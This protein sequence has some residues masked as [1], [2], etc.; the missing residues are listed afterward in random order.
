M[1]FLCQIVV[2]IYLD[3]A[4]SLQNDIIKQNDAKMLFFA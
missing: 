1:Y 3:G 2:K 4:Y